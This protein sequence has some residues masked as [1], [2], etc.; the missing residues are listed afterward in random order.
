MATLTTEERALIRRRIAKKAIEQDVDIAWVKGAV[1]DA[2]QAIEDI[3]TSATLQ[4][5][6]S[7]AIDAA[8]SP[9]GVTFTAQEKRW[10]V[11]LVMSAKCN[12]DI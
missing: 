6:V 10:I 3:L 9:Y 8:A 2:A 1:N 11:A 7:G 12:R 5:Q 4:T